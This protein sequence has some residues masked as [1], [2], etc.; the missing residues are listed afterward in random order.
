MASSINPFDFAAEDLAA[1]LAKAA[2]DGTFA[3]LIQAAKKDQAG[4][5]ADATEIDEAAGALY[6]NTVDDFI[7]AAYPLLRSWATYVPPS[8]PPYISPTT[9]LEVDWTAEPSSGPLA[10][11]PIS[12][13]GKTWTV[14]N[15]ATAAQFEIVNGA[16]LSMEILPF[17]SVNLNLGMSGTGPMIHALL[18]DLASATRRA[19]LPISIWAHYGSYSLPASS[20]MLVSGIGVPAPY[21]TWTWSGGIRNSLGTAY[22]GGKRGSLNDHGIVAMGSADVIMFH[23]PF[24]GVIQVFFGTWSGGWPAREDMV[25]ALRSGITTSNF[26]DQVLVRVPGARFLIGAESNGSHAGGAAF[27]LEHSKIEIG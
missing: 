23:L 18:E 2:G 14:A 4:L 6:G 19:D 16:G 8:L 11:G 13:A 9:V 12:V 3:D 1:F 24:D 22:P 25:L 7:L 27:T 20:N 26:E 21:T 15:V 10:N 17:T 5:E